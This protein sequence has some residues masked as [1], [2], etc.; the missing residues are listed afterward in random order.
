[1]RERIVPAASIVAIANLFEPRRPY[2]ESV[3]PGPVVTHID[4]PGHKSPSNLGL[5]KGS[6]APRQLTH[7]AGY[8]VGMSTDCKHEFCIIQLLDANRNRLNVMSR[9]FVDMVGL[10]DTASDPK[11]SG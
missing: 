2:V 11:S 3:Q 5:A 7:D 10:Y 1:M 6:E 9:G 8:A 4:T